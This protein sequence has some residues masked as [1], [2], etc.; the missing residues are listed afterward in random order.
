MR[1]AAKRRIIPGTVFVST[2]FQYL[3]RP[4][5]RV[6]KVK[7]LSFV[8]CPLSVLST[9]AQLN[10]LGTSTTAKAVTCHMVALTGSTG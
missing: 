8:T 5:A 3:P 10:R 9:K 2:W 4:A 1:A 7:A 6:L